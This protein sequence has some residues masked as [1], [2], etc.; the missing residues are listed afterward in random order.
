M[1]QWDERCTKLA[2]S[3]NQN[4]HIGTRQDTHSRARFFFKYSLMTN[5]ISFCHR[6]F[7]SKDMRATVNSYFG[8]LLMYLLKLLVLEIV[9]ESV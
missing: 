7:L 4:M 9:I 6:S 2:H 8:Y 5:L 3:R 1:G